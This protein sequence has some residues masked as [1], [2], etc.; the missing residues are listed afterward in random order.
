MLGCELF[1]HRF[2]DGGVDVVGNLPEGTY[3]RPQGPALLPSGAELGVAAVARV[4]TIAAV[5]LL[6][7]CGGSPGRPFVYVIF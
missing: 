7:P 6:V 3:D 1:C 5:E 4:P 2:G